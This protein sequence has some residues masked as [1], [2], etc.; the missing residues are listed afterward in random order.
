MRWGRRG[1]PKS[2][3]SARVRAAR[4]FPWG[5]R[6]G[7]IEYTERNWLVWTLPVLL[8]PLL[9]WVCTPFNR[10][11]TWRRVVWTYVLPVV[12][13]IAM[14]DGLVSNPRTYSVTELR[15]LVERIES[16]KFRWRIGRIASIGPSRV[17]YLIGTT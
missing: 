2:S 5:R 6:S 10:P 7:V 1:R 14:W 3:I 17:T 11:L 15:V 8:I 12:P 4:S 16:Q 9:V 13:V